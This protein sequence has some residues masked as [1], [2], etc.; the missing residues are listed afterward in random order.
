MNKP[1]TQWSS[2]AARWVAVALGI[3]VSS[4]IAAALH[5][6]PAS[7]AAKVR[8]FESDEPGKSA[9]GFTALVGTWE[10]ARDGDNNVLAQ[11]AK[12]DD[13]TFNGRL[14]LHGPGP[15]RP[16]VQGRRPVLLRRSQ[17]RRVDPLG[18]GGRGDGA[19][20]NR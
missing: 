5:G 2:A 11:K 18:A 4:A 7:F 13:A 15:D 8:N 20:Y 14:N 19:G 6:R 9:Q 17:H 12:S 10:V 3:A 1:R 16:V